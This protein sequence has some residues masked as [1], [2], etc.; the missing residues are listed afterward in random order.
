[1][2]ELIRTAG[3]WPANV[4]TLAVD[5]GG[6][7]LAAAVVDG[8]GVIE[9][10]ATAPTPRGVD[11]DVVFDA[12]LSVIDDLG[13]D[14]LGDD[15]AA[16]GIGCGGPMSPG[17]ATVS[18]LNIPAWRDFPLVARLTGVIDVPT[19]RPRYPKRCTRA[20]FNAALRSTLAALTITGFRLSCSA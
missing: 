20:T 9:R 19:A 17:G 15:L 3:S 16:C 8:R 4:K 7:K 18:P 12:L 2:P 10:Q 5:V 6:T 11:G 1:M 14:D 13:L